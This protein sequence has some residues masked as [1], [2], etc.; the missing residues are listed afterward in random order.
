MRTARVLRYLL[1][2]RD[3]FTKLL[4]TVNLS[5]VTTAEVS[6]QFVNHW[7]FSYGPSIGLIAYNGRQFT[8]KL[9][10][11]VC[12]ILNAQKSFMATYH[13]QTNGQVERLNRIILSTLRAFV[14]DHPRDWYLYR[15]T[16]A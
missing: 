7:V 6:K 13:R 10:Q 2:I 5:S 1:V 11:N 8:F 4:R 3:C 12:K 9:F 14:S 16:L 15:S